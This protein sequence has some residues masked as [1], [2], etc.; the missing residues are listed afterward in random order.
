MKI[1]IGSWNIW[2][3]GPRDFKGIAKVVKEN[4][5]D[6]LGVQEAGVYFD[7][8]KEN[9]AEKIAEELDFHYIFYPASDIIHKDSYRVGNAIFSRFPIIESKCYQL[10]PPNIK[11]D[12]T[13][14]TE[15][16]VLVYSKIQLDDD[17]SLNFLTTHLQFSLKFKTTAIRLVQ[18]ENILSV[19]KKLDD[20]I[21]LTGDFNTVPQNE[22]IRKIEDLLTRVDGNEPTWTIYPFEKDGWHVE[23]LKYR[24]DNIFVSKDTA[25]KNF[26]IIKSKISDHLPI[27][28]GIDAE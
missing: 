21:V 13:Y 22:E 20:P 14:E 18:V 19:I 15:P 5:I 3:F 8:G 11:Y 28:I 17:K 27:K 2:I 4:K 6:I 9:M 25:Y 23:E 7:K 16:R 10:N 24:L 12:G 26:E 1:N